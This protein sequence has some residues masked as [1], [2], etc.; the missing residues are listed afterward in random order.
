LYGTSQAEPLGA[1]SPFEEIPSMPELSR[2]LIVEAD[3]GVRR[4]LSG[5][6]LD[7]LVFSDAAA[8]A[9]SSM[10]L[11]AGADFGVVILDLLL[12]DA[13]VVLQAIQRMPPERRPMVIGTGARDMAHE[14]DDNLVQ[15]V[16]RKP[17]ALRQFADVIR[18]CLEA[19]PRWR[20]ASVS[21]QSD[22]LRT[23]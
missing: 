12:A 6:L 11:L 14:L 20:K 21:P 23:L 7:K 13:G 8:D 9:A 22:A 16:I 19:A 3:E 18:S 10:E 4:K 1:G 2:A 17:I 5:A 15:I